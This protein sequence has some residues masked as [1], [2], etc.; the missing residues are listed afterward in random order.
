MS[1]RGSALALL[2]ATALAAGA[3]RR[4]EPPPPPPAPYA[5]PDLPSAG[6]PA[7]PAVGFADATPESGVTFSHV[8]GAAGK[9]YLP[10]TMGSGV[11]VFDWDGDERLDLFF[12]Q[13]RPWP[14]DENGPLP[15]CELWRNL[16]AWRFENVTAR[17]GLA[18][19][20]LQGMG[21]TAAD[22][23]ADGDADL[24]VTAAGPAR[25]LRNDG[26]SF[27]DVT[28][29]A[30]VGGAPWTDAEGREHAPWSTAAAWLDFDL[31]GRLDLFVGHYVKWSR[32]HD[33]FT[34]VNGRDKAYTIPTSYEADTCRLYRGRGDGTFEDVTEP[35]GVLKR[36]AKALG[37]AVEDFNADGRPDLAVANDTQPNFLYLS[38]PE[39]GYVETALSAGIAYD[40]TG[41]ARAG[42]GIDAGELAG[43]GRLAI[44]IGN[45]SRE[46]VSLYS[47][48][49]KGFFVDR[50][51]RAGLARH[52]LLPLTFGLQ[53]LD[54]DLDGALDLVLAN[55][56]IEPEIQEVQEDVPF[57]QPPQL[58][59]NRGDGTFAPASA[60]AGEAFARPLVG[61]GLAS[62]D[63]DGDGDLDLVITTNAGRPLLLRNDGATGNHWLRVRLVGAGANREALGAAVTLTAGGR[64]QRRYLRTGSSYLSQ[65]ELTLTFGLGSATAVDSLE[66][67]WPTGKVERYP[68]EAVDRELVL[69]E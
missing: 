14:G 49:A 68:V 65:S 63:L 47:A 19:L 1:R 46:A 55:G 22:F 11:V 43:G 6:G 62:G 53:F 39:G 59:W 9:K 35:A 42:M 48:D 23:D 54:Y 15:S 69:R 28:E 13:G 24:F 52:T 57:A 51:A 36:E 33:V 34:T 50:A 38:R 66:V 18:G 44:A 58:F 17:A 10:E 30:G 67:R 21:A 25:L 4:A 60:T 40:E 26:G 5:K 7:P 27:R 20:S 64:A 8:N 56:H 2:A 12:V 41:R 45:F 61:R 37:V 3:C 31:D 32:E 29:R 16:G